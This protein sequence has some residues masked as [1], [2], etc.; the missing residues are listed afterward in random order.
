MKMLAKTKGAQNV[1]TL[2]MCP[3]V[4]VFFHIWLLPCM[5]HTS[6][7]DCGPM[8]ASKLRKNNA[9][10]FFSFPVPF[11]YGAGWTIFSIRSRCSSLIVI[12]PSS[13]APSSL[14]PLLLML[15]LPLLLLLLNFT[16]SARVQRHTQHDFIQTGPRLLDSV[17]VIPKNI[18][19][20]VQHTC[21]ICYFGRN[22]HKYL[23][24][25][26]MF[27]NFRESERAGASHST[28]ISLVALCGW[29]WMN[30]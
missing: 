24:N 30:V 19:M 20:R 21:F 27:D 23:H 11:V 5:R 28:N 2:V 7:L 17:S 12:S 29:E 16:I 14:T 10:I 15:M 8:R 13:F 6:D 1:P 22:F 4:C 3:C 26:E 18:H 25:A 9:Y